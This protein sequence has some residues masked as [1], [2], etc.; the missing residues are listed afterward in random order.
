MT[1]NE[2]K[3]HYDKRIGLLAKIII[4]RQWN[5]SDLPRLERLTLLVVYYN[6][7][8]EGECVLRGEGTEV[9]VK[10]LSEGTYK[11]EL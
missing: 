3:Q 8:Y 11:P 2:L 9:T 7:R 5:F 10:G 4:N 1:E 6:D